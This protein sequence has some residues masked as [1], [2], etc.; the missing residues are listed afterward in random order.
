MQD[1]QTNKIVERILSL[2]LIDDKA[3][4]SSTGLVD[5]RL[6]KGEQK[7]IAV[8]DPKVSL[9][10]LKYSKGILPEALKGTFTSFKALLKFSEGYF[11]RRNIRISE[12][13]NAAAD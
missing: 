11:N 6:F 2:S 10:T 5:R 7:L 9:W 3:P 12:E 13:L 1:L 8:Q 4:V